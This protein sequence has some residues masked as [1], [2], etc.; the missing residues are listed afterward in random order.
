MV[1]T[2]L[3]NL[4][5]FAEVGELKR[6]AMQYDNNRRPSGSAE[7]VYMRRSDAAPVSARVNVTGLNGRMKR[8]VFIGKGIRGGSG[9]GAAPSVRHR[10]NPIH[11]Q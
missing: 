6:H 3:R 7:V 4:G 8:S 1:C 5:L 10:S 11:N 2:T 9:R